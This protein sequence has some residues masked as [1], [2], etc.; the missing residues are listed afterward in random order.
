MTSFATYSYPRPPQTSS[1]TYLEPTLH[2]DLP[3]SLPSLF[4]YVRCHAL[5]CDL[6]NT[7]S[8]SR[9]TSH[10][11][12]STLVDHAAH[13][14]LYRELLALGAVLHIHIYAHYVLNPSIHHICIL[15]SQ[16]SHRCHN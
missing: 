4:H 10:N 16:P 6:S 5:F 2:V 9:R 14:M 11:Y 15:S 1:T 3:P 8:T 12:H 13:E 7:D